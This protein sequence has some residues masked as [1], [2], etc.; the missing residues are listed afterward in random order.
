MEENKELEQNVQETT[1]PE[2][3]PSIDDTIQNEVEPAAVEVE[4]PVSSLEENGPIEEAVKP[5]PTYNN[6]GDNKKSKTPIIATICAVILVVLGAF[7]AYTKMFNAKSVFTK[8]IDKKYDKLEKWIDDNWDTKKVGKTAIVKQDVKLKITADPTIVKDASTKAMLDELNKLEIKSE[9]GVDAKNNNLKMIINALYDNSDLINVGTYLNDGKY[10]VE[11]KG[12]YDKYIDITDMVKTEGTDINI[13]K[14][15]VKYIL[16][17]VKDSFNKNLNSKDFKKSKETVVIDGKK[18]KT[19]KITY[20]FTQKTIDEL[21]YKMVED[22]ENDS[23]FVK[24]I[25][26]IADTKESEIKKSLK[27]AVKKIKEDMKSADSKESISLSCYVKG[28]TNSFVGFSLE[29]STSKT[30]A[31]Y[32]E[33]G[34]TK[35]FNIVGSGSE[36]VALKK[37]DK[38]TIDMKSGDKSVA[39]IEVVKNT[40][41][42]KTT[43]SYK[44]LSNGTTVMDGTISYDGDKDN[45][46]IVV[47]GSVMGLVKVNLTDKISTKYVDKIDMPSF[48]NSVKY[49]N[50][51]EAEKTQIQNRLNNSLGFQK[52]MRSLQTV[53]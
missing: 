11:L 27:E 39:A 31:T 14:D 25:A 26:K 33:N 35:Q 34:A 43:Y 12:L 17:T 3:L 9:V 38:L 30:K 10:Y 52:L 47:T 1:T 7:V 18:V 15:D 51:T 13:S 28:L 23:K 19:T 42:N 16:R 8:S 32:Y 5:A 29:T 49:E 48:T 22:L 41:G 4:A 6:D 24:I 53:R 37:D 50:I 40:K 21:S 36:L 2:S 46:T 45:G 44:V 20:K